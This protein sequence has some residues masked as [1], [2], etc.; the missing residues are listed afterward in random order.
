MGK[1]K[2]ITNIENIAHSLRVFSMILL[3]V[4]CSFNGCNALRESNMKRLYWI[5][6]SQYFSLRTIV[7]CFV[8]DLFCTVYRR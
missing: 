3:V 5:R 4:W 1:R 2:S 6:L 8:P 7:R